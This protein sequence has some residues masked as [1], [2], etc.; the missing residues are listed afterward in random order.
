MR[1]LPSF[2]VAL[3]A[4]ILIVPA[5]AQVPCF[6]PS[7]GQNLG[8]GDDAG[9]GG[10][11]LGFSFPSGGQGYTT[12]AVCSNGYLWLGSAPAT[13]PWDYSPT[14]AELLAGTPRICPMWN[15]FNPSAAGSGQV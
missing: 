4:A 14:E 15:D 10:L 13:N 11:Q 3:T 12:S 9:A 2:R 6:D 8:L 7:F 5:A 1:S